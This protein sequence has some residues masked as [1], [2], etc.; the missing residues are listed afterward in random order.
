MPGITTISLTQV[1]MKA[2]R[3]VILLSSRNSFMSWA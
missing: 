2:L 1:S 3:S